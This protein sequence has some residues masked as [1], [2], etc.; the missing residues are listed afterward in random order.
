MGEV[1]S[2]GAVTRKSRAGLT[3]PLGKI[4]SRSWSSASPSSFQRND[5]S[6]LVEKG[7]QDLLFAADSLSGH[8]ESIISGS[9]QYVRA[10]LLRPRDIRERSRT[11]LRCRLSAR[12]LGHTVFG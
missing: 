5:L 1:C 9:V 4:G 3:N 10:P 12:G 7:R 11:K 2:R 8:R 6:L